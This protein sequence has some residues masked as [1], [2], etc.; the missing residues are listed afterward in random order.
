MPK[1]PQA[2]RDPSSPAGNED[3]YYK[4]TRLAR[5]AEF[6][7]Q[8]LSSAVARLGWISEARAGRDPVIRTL[9]GPVTGSAKHGVP[10]PGTTRIASEARRV[11]PVTALR[12]ATVSHGKRDYLFDAFLFFLYWI[13]FTSYNL[14]TSITTVTCGSE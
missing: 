13:L 12:G 4:A 8:H 11:M 5:P 1:E 6:A 9:Y 2:V 7:Y 10:P 3:G 14:F